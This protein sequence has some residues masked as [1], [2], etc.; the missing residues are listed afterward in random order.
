MDGSDFARFPVA[1]QCL[2]GPFYNLGVC[3]NAATISEAILDGVLDWT[4]AE[5][6]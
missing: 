4:L 5:P 1:E 6:A 2:A 3:F